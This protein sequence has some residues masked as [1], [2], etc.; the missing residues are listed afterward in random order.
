MYPHRPNNSGAGPTGDGHP[1]GGSGALNPGTSLS[2]GGFGN[3]NT[4][5]TF[6][7]TSTCIFP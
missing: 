2:A 6:W 3:I 7:T 1:T 5:G 4:I